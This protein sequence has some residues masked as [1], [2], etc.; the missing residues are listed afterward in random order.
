MYIIRLLLLAFISILLHYDRRSQSETFIVFANIH[1]FAIFDSSYDSYGE[2]AVFFH[3]MIMF[4]P[5][6]FLCFQL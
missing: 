6:H 4:F 3:T 5:T 1:L 2:S